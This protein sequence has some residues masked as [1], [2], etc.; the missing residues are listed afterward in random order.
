[1]ANVTTSALTVDDGV[2]TF[3]SAAT[4]QITIEGTY[5]ADAVLELKQAGQADSWT[6]R[7]DTDGSDQFQIRYGSDYHFKISTNG[8]TYIDGVGGDGVLWLEGG[9]TVASMYFENSSSGTTWQIGKSSDMGGNDFFGFRQEGN[10]RAYFDADGDFT[11]TAGKSIQAS[12][13]ALNLKD[14]L[15]LNNNGSTSL[16]Y[17]PGGIVIISD[18]NDNQT[19][20]DIIF[21]SNSTTNASGMNEMM[22]ITDPDG[23][24]GG[25][26]GIG[27][28]S[29]AAR[30][31]VETAA[32]SSKP[33][34]YV[35]NAF[36]NTTEP[37]A[38]FEN[39][40]S[41]NGQKPLV[42]IETA[43]ATNDQPALVVLNGKV[44]IGDDAP[45]TLLHLK[46]AAPDISYEDTDG[47]DKYIAGNN[48][49]NFR[50]RNATDSRTDLNIDGAGNAGIGTTSPSTFKSQYADGT[51]L[52]ISGNLPL[53]IGS[54]DNGA[55]RTNTTKKAARIVMPHYTN[56]EEPTAIIM[57]ISDQNSS[58]VKIGGGSDWMNA[59]EQIDFYTAGNTTT[60]T[61][62]VRGTFN[63][64][65]NFYIYQ[66]MIMQHTKGLYFDG[67]SDVYLTSA[68]GNRFSVYSGGSER[69]RID[70]SNFTITGT[71]VP[72]AD[73]SRNF[74]SASYRWLDIFSSKLKVA[75]GNAS[76]PSHTFA[77][78]TTM[79]MYR[80]G[81]NTLALATGGTARIEMNNTSINYI[82]RISVTG[83][84][85]PWCTLTA[86]TGCTIVRQDWTQPGGS[87][88]PYYVK[89]WFEI[90]QSTGSTKKLR[91][92]FT[93]GANGITF[94]HITE[95]TGEYPSGYQRMLR[96]NCQ[97]TDG[98]GAIFHSESSENFSSAGAWAS[99][100][101]TND[102]IWESAAII[103]SAGAMYGWVE[104]M[105]HRGSGT[106][107]TEIEIDY[108]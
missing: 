10:V 9:T 28:A 61:G 58:H 48:G 95:I 30:L 60:A 107:P 34:L 31:H 27:T 77:N 50:I 65:G 11:I 14:R 63:D 6:M 7:M 70:E 66:N 59:V 94:A 43:A 56:A 67:G 106:I 88:D 68:A 25:S 98:G 93:R 15:F 16:W 90:A 103:A 38:H 54:D 35:K 20:C 26:V 24:Y 104:F 80:P 84:T 1:M 71:M 46:S 3:P 19:D 64:S 8:S 72:E 79:G 40:N 12:S 17:A 55:G 22:R 44:G 53:V 57:G 76:G 105:I 51:T 82:T 2:V 37:I 101:G 108:S 18:D 32:I 73:A 102:V 42:Q 62:T 45:E 13:G 5:P 23:T 4:S 47:G 49:G 83:G 36:Y 75:D 81:T 29:P 52:D 96:A 85:A 74:G 99:T 89:V 97:T 100:S 39:T 41:N 92:T 87:Y 69:L 86:G 33:L 21:G 91:Y 78:D